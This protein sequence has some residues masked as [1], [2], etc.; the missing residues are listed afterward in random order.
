MA[1]PALRARIKPERKRAQAEPEVLP[2]EAIGLNPQQ[3]A[4]P[5]VQLEVLDGLPVLVFLERAGK[6]VFANAEARELLDLTEGEWVHRPVEDVLWG[7]F[8]GTAEPQTLLTGTRRGSPFHATLPAKN[9]Q[10]VPVEGTY[11]I[12]N[13]E[14]RDAVIVAHPSG[15]ERAPKSRLMEDVL[16]S[17]PE[18]VAIEHKNHILYTNPAFT[19]MFGYTAEEA[20]GGSLRELIVPETRF[21]ENAALLKAVDERGGAT[22]ETVRMNK[23]G[24]LVDVSLQIAPLLVNDAKVGY[25]FTFRDIGDYKQ[26]EAKLQHDAMHDVVTGLP[27]RALF[28][29]RLNLTLSRRVRHPDHGC[30]VLYVDLDRFKEV[31]DVLGHAAGDVLLMAVAGRLRASLRPQD[32]A[33]RL[34][35]DEFAVLV[36]NIVTAYDLEIVASRILQEIK[37]P[38]D[39]FGHVVEAGASIGAAMAGPDHTA[40]EMLIRDADFAMYRAKQSGGGRYEVFDK[41]L[42]VC[43]TSQQERERELRT[44]LDK[45]QFAFRYQPIYRLASGKLEGFE[46]L[47][48]LRRADGT[49]E[50]F[51]DLLT[52]AEDTG[53]SILLGQE[54]FDAVCAQLRSWS[55][56]LPQQ[57]LIVTINLTRRQLYHPDLIAQLK[58]ALAASGADASRLLFEAPESAFNENP[59]AAVAILQRLADCNVRVAV[60]EF[61]SS[62]APLNYLVNLPVSM[63]KLAPRLTATAVSPGRQQA[64]LESLIRLGYTLGVDVVAQGIEAPEQLAR[65]VRMGCALGQGPLLSPALE[66]AQALQL[67]ETG[68]WTILPKA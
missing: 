48:C 13:A 38:F 8:P 64:A 67:A 36:E 23:A 53:I 18:A 15:R 40:A 27:N 63:V 2:R 29:D 65:L 25:V 10:L 31:N 1:A 60:D 17:L 12:L 33:A 46:S 42:E 6:I 4:N 50:S 16:A 22:V 43:V 26:T 37:R 39:I 32:S 44:A 24:E 21:N 61:G 20:S 9:G 19:G 35:G 7:L 47:L 58:K 56:R 57:G 30:G 59:D 62:L 54:T 51:S 55:D 3:N 34:G 66:P 14:L 52:V 68:Y 5:D 45:R 11:S 49:I 41:H 28:L